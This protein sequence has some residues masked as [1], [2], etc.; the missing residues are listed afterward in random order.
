MY[1]F[2]LDRKLYIDVILHSYF[3]N[4]MCYAL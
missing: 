3:I 1:I 2:V 4:I